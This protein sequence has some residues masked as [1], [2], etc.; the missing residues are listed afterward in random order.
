MNMS[1]APE[2]A[3]RCRV[4]VAECLEYFS[5]LIQIRRA[6]NGDDLISGLIQTRDDGSVLTTY[7]IAAVCILLMVTGQEITS[8]LIG[9][10]GLIFSGHPREFRQLADDP[11]LRDDTI[12]EILRLEPPAQ[13][14]STVARE[15]VRLRDAVIEPGDAVIVL[16]GSANKEGMGLRGP[17]ALAVETRRRGAL[18]WT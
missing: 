10:A 17:A 8:N 7:E 16:I 1:V 6:G 11:G 9:N 5:R 4:A 12:D 2:V 3:V 13:V 14:A 18:T 15:K